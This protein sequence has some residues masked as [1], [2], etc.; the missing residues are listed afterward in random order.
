MENKIQQHI[1]NYLQLLI[2]KKV[3]E[4][5]AFDL[6]AT[7]IF[8]IYLSDKQNNDIPEIKESDEK[9]FFENIILSPESNLEENINVALGAW[10]KLLKVDTNMFLIKE[11]IFLD[12]GIHEFR[13]LCLEIKDIFGIKWSWSAENIINLFNSIES[14]IADRI[15]AAHLLFTP[16]EIARLMS[17]FS[18][19]KT[20]NSLYDPYYRT[21][22]LLAECTVA[23]KKIN[24][25][26]GNTDNM[27]SFKITKIKSVMLRFREPDL[28]KHDI[29]NSFRTEKFDY[30]IT[31]PPF[32][33]ARN[34]PLGNGKWTRQFGGHRTELDILCIALD[35]LNDKGQ[36]AI[37]VP[38]G[39]LFATDKVFNF[40]KK[41]IEENLL[42]SIILLPQKIFYGANIKTAILLINTKKKDNKVLLFDATDLGLK[43]KDRYIFSE[44][45]ISEI[46]KTVKSFKTEI[47]INDG[48]LK[49]HV[50]VV[51][52]EELK[53]HNFDCQFVTYRKTKITCD[54]KLQPAAFIWEEI[55]QLKRELEVC[56]KAKEELID[57]RNI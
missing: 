30:I 9:Y 23:N 22:E 34:F 15:T 56:Q 32:D 52:G 27:L 45:D 24:C 13:N 25:I 29:Y 12:V 50:I 36:A 19:F 10:A 18:T 46:A 14:E 51:T 48:R 26:R 8:W 37:I 5:D 2:H 39:L 55:R 49:E 41:I 17:K 11:T 3:Y 44:S 33:A 54:L 38:N 57:V 35:H 42:E 7:L 1:S 31:N 16:P 28:S 53:A 20:V 40:R 43:R 4:Q 6:L 47:L 21:G